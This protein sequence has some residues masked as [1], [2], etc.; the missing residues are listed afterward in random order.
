MSIIS[1]SRVPAVLMAA[2]VSTVAVTGVA[3]AAT[4]LP[5]AG[6]TTTRAVAGTTTTAKPS[7]GAGSGSDTRK[8]MTCEQGKALATGWLTLGNIENQAGHRE[9]A[10]ADTER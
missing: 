3:T 4:A 8:G 7:S 1:M 2:A 5:A 9:M 10:L 6:T